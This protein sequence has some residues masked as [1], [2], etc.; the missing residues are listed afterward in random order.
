ML[1][2][3]TCEDHLLYSPSNFPTKDS[4]DLMV[5]CAL[6]KSNFNCAAS[7]VRFSNL[8]K[9]QQAMNGQEK[10]KLPPYDKLPKFLWS[11]LRAH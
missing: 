5:S 11:I 2:H 9:K 4:A 1:T 7:L 10:P 8:T 6:S 3:S